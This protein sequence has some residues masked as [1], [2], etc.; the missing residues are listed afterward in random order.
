MLQFYL[1]QFFKFTMCSITFI[2]TS[3]WSS[4]CKVQTFNKL[5]IRDLRH[6]ILF[7]LI[8]CNDS[9]GHI[10]VTFTTTN[11][12]FKWYNFKFTFG[13]ISDRFRDT[14]DTIRNL[15]NT[16]IT[17]LKFQVFKTAICTLIALLLLTLIFA[18]TRRTHTLANTFIHLNTLRN[19]WGNHRCT[20][21]IASKW[22]TNLN[23]TL[24]VIW[25]VSVNF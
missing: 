8:H 19:N 5:A 14:N 23:L 13:I 21:V 3:M 25:H 10:T 20:G 9:K 15:V 17:L 11:E 4:M 2:A 22:L 6:I 16:C 12:L 7:N 1:S 24:H 18:S